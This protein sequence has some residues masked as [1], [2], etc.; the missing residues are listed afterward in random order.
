[1]VANQSRRGLPGM[2]PNL[3]RRSKNDHLGC[4]DRGG[5]V[6]RSAVIANE[7][8]R[9]GDDRDQLADPQ[10]AQCRQGCWRRRGDGR[11]LCALLLGR[12][13]GHDDLKSTTGQLGSDRGEPLREPALGIEFVRR[14]QHDVGTPWID[15]GGDQPGLGRLPK[16]RRDLKMGWEVGWRGLLTRQP[17]PSEHVP[18]ILDRV[19]LLTAAGAPQDLIDLRNP[20]IAG[21]RGA[22]VCRRD[23]K[24]GAAEKHELG[25]GRTTV[26]I[27]HRGEATTTYFAHRRQPCTQIAPALLVTP[28]QR[29]R[30]DI[31]VSGEKI[32]VDRFDQRREP[33]I[34][35]PAL[36]RTQIGRVK[37][38]LAKV[39][40][41]DKEDGCP[42]RQLLEERSGHQAVT[43]SASIVDSSTSRT[44]IS[45]RIG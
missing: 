25:T 4:P 34:G 35:T 7:E 29:Q 38:G 24:A 9:S 40:K 6:C 23:P 12:G 42:V 14:S 21:K 44:G 20:K 32:G 41:P 39:A 30:L 43:D 31:R 2:P 17:K 11:Q 3:A 10:L 15:P 13:P 33:Q 28:G 16:G 36:Q 37:Y 45:S 5:N 18:L 22:K 8:A 26:E 27:D 1:M 19:E